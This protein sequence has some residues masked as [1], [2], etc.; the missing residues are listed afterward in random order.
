MKKSDGILVLEGLDHLSTRFGTKN[1]WHNQCIY[2]FSKEPIASEFITLDPPCYEAIGL[3]EAN[4][5]VFT[6][7]CSFL[8]WPEKDCLLIHLEKNIPP[9]LTNLKELQYLGEWRVWEFMIPSE[10]QPMTRITIHRVEEVPDIK[11]YESLEPDDQIGGQGPHDAYTEWY[12]CKEGN[13]D[14]VGKFRLTSLEESTVL[15]SRYYLTAKG[16]NFESQI[17]SS[18]ENHLYFKKKKRILAFE[19]KTLQE[20]NLLENRFQNC[21]S[22]YASRIKINDS[23]LRKL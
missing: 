1:K 19:T 22:I 13:K 5:Q 20:K 21:L 4:Q 16:K 8:K 3:S 15:L 2:F 17:F 6:D 14:I 7:L 9:K 12:L 11:E 18:I 10:V 23:H